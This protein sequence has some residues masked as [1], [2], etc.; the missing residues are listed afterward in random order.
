[1]IQIYT[2]A[3]LK[4]MKSKT[5]WTRVAKMTDADIDYSD[6]PD[7]SEM[8]KRGEV[9][10][11]GRPRKANPKQHVNLRLDPDIVE[12]FKKTGCGW[13]TRIN[14]TLRDWLKIRSLL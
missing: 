9:R 11:V 14:D 3:Q 4:K 7:V 5:D 13:Q 1:M 10:P 12:A 6:L 8:M 2:T